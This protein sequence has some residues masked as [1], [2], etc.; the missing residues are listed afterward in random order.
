MKKE[1]LVKTI[2]LGIVVLFIEIAITPSIGIS[3]YLD[4]TTPPVTTISFNPPEPDGEN[5][6]YV[7]IVTVTLNAT[8]DDSGV[9]VTY[10]R[11]DGGIWYNYTEPF[12]LVDDGEDIFIEFYSVDNVGNQEEIK[13]D[14]VDI[15]KTKPDVSLEYEVIGGNPQ[16]GWD[17]LF[18]AIA[19]DY[20]SGMD[21][22]EFYVKFY[23]NT[24]LEETVKGVGP[25]YCW[26]YHYPYYEFIVRG[27][28]FNPEITDEYVKFFA[29]MV[30]I[31]K[32]KP[33]YIEIY[34][35]SYDVAGNWD[36]YG[37]SNSCSKVTISSGIYL[38]K[39]LTLPSD[40]EGY[41]GKFFIRAKF[42][43]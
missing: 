14:V 30:G 39:N 20:V 43:T 5:G 6:W 34:A 37:I 4:D 36:F 38:F 24:H 1:W 28:I 10:Y 21:R 3:N 22:V 31:L 12:I 7:S 11:V 17:F 35:Y 32:F 42:Y 33:P 13:S 23:D 18:T 16:D 27:L 2:A 15:D 29:V 25:A 19:T 8:D 40:Y 41:I 26:I 9:N